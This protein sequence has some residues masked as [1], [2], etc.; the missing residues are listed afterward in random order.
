MSAV[1]LTEEQ[2]AA[3]VELL[4]RRRTDSIW[5]GWIQRVILWRG[6]T[7]LRSFVRGWTQRL[8]LQPGAPPLVTT[9]ESWRAPT[10]LS[11]ELPQ[12][13]WFPGE[14]AVQKDVLCDGWIQNF[15]LLH[16][17]ARPLSRRRRQDRL[18][19]GKRRHGALGLASF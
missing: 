19:G 2:I 12:P 5:R 1:N 11:P 9:W 3:A 17:R 18:L 10:D 8:S 7:Q 13:V 15:S 6:A 4:R 14:S 16:K